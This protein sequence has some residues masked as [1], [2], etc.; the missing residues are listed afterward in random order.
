MLIV[1]LDAVQ[2]GGGIEAFETVHDLDQTDAPVFLDQ[3]FQF[4]QDIVHVGLGH[5]ADDAN[6][7]DR[8]GFVL[9]VNAGHR[10]LLFFWETIS[11][12]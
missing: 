9:G 5:P 10:R 1:E 8:R 7:G 2:N 11:R 12:A 6:L 4:R 3:R